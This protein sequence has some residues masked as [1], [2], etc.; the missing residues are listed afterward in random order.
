MVQAAQDRRPTSATSTGELLAQLREA[1]HRTERLTEDLSSQELMGPYL[2]IVNPVP[3]G[4]GHVAWFTPDRSD[5]F[6]GFRT[7][8]M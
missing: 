3:R 2:G 4:I 7:C 8:A 5:V 6:V 1:R